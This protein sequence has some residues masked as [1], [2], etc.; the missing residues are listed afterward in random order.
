MAKV[1]KRSKRLFLAFFRKLL[2]KNCVFLPSVAF[3]IS[4]DR[5]QRRFQ[6]TFMET[7]KIDAI[8]IY[9]NEAF[10]LVRGSNPWEVRIPPH[11]YLFRCQEK[12]LEFFLIF[13]QVQLA[14]MLIDPTFV[15][16]IMQ[17]L[18]RSGFFFLQTIFDFLNSHF[19]PN[20]LNIIQKV[21]LPWAQM[22]KVISA[23]IIFRKVMGH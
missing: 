13:C 22:W 21:L 11:L 3:K 20:F 23:V 2:T 18:C 1:I 10:W 12:P 8:K 16:K 14:C 19:W 7:S 9:Q 4:I 5:H 6:K 17:Y 15:T